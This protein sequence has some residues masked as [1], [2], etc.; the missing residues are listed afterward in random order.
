MKDTKP[1]I[2]AVNLDILLVCSF[3]IIINEIISPKGILRELFMVM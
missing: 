3:Q 2:K 1:T